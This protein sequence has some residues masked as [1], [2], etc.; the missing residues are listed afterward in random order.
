LLNYFPILVLA[1]LGREDRKRG[2]GKKGDDRGFSFHSCLDAPNAD[3]IR[4]NRG[5]IRGCVQRKIESAG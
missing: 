3:R 2:S 1:R 5:G 4:Q